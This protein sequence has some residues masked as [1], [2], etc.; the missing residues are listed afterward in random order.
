MVRPSFEELLEKYKKKGATH[1]QKKSCPS[2][3]D[4]KPSTRHQEQLAHQLQG[5]RV[6][7]P[8]PISGRLLGGLRYILAI[9]RLGIIQVSL[10][11]AIH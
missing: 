2:K 10:Y 5:N 11:M 4:L 6:V 8:Y 9:T 1:K 3:K 7:V